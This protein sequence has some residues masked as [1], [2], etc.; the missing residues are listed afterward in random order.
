MW[1]LALPGQGAVPSRGEG[2]DEGED[3]AKS[4]REEGR[5]W[6]GCIPLCWK[7]REKAAEPLAKDK[8]REEK[9]KIM[10]EEHK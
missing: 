5:L 8:T 10:C 9:E 1:V 7:T 3:T 6:R 2:E 4:F